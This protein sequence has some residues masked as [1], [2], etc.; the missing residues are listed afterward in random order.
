MN[1]RKNWLHWLT[2]GLWLLWLAFW[3]EVAI[4]SWKELE[5]RAFTISLI[6]FV[7]SLVV[8]AGLWLKGRARSSH[9]AS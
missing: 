6:V 3:A 2:R 5:S 8:G 1:R 9:K 7:V 4:G